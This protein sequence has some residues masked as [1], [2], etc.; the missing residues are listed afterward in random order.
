MP[1][2]FDI[3]RT[4][5][6]TC[7]V[8][9]GAGMGVL[10][11][12]SL[13]TCPT[14]ATLSAFPGATGY[15]ANAVGGRG[16]RVIYVTNLNDS[17]PGSLRAAI[18]ATGPRTVLFKVSGTINARSNLAIR[19]PFITIAGQTAPGDGI[20]I[21][22]AEL[23]IISNDVVIRFLRVRLGDLVVADRDAI[24]I[25]NSRDVI[26]DHVSASWGVDE[27]LSVADSRNITYQW[28][29]IGEPLNNSVH[30][31]GPHGKC[32][33]VRGSESVSIHHNLFAN[34]PDRSPH[35][36][37]KRVYPPK[38]QVV[39]NVIFDYGDSGTKIE[40][41]DDPNPAPGDYDVINNLYMAGPNSR[42]E[43]AIKPMLTGGRIFVS[44]NLGPRRTSQLGDD[45]SLVTL[46]GGEASLRV[47][48][49]SLTLL[50]N[51]TAPQIAYDNVLRYAGAIVPRRDAV[52]ERILEKV[53]NRQAGWIN[54]QRD[55]GGWPSLTSGSAPPD[56]D[57]DGMP[58]AWE[59]AQGLNPADASDGAAV[60]RGSVY[61]KLERYLHSLVEAALPP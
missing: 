14:A 46:D 5:L 58:D 13:Q 31:A 3:F 20:T 59:I 52:D 57:G 48:A 27:V 12:T 61:T 11:Q 37:A 44:G 36:S 15:G 10:A 54:S 4:A 22:N 41:R 50:P 42:S 35:L 16:G 19:E 26:L 40:A 17:G 29:I 21:A 47:N 56:T 6:L 53:R 38:M 49:A 32:S 33:L 28:S 43:I 7:V 18:D 30:S 23:S 39:N 55:V 34:C 51:T 45:W 24:A 2:I 60:V 9:A 8:C 25:V 1:G